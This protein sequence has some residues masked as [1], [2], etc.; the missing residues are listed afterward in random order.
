MPRRRKPMALTPMASDPGYLEWLHEQWRANGYVPDSVRNSPEYQAQQDQL[1][2]H[3]ETNPRSCPCDWCA[4][5]RAEI[6]KR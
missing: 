5:I 1:H 2:A 4:L 6:R 3:F